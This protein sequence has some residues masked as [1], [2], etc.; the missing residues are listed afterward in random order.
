MIAVSYRQA[1]VPDRLLGR[2]MAAYRVIA[3]GSIPV[4]AVL[5]GLAARLG[6]N[7]LSFI[8]GGI[9]ALVAVFY[10]VSNLRDVDLNP[11][12]VDSPTSL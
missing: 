11:A 4:G 3:H 5:G 6:G 2:I 7:R 8:V 9:V 1:A 12:P 10:V